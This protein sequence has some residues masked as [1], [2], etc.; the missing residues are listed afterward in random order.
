MER[1]D[2]L[3]PAV[4]L[5]GGL[6]TRL[7]GLFPELPKPMVPIAGR[8]FLEYVLRYVASSGIQRA[9]LCVG[10]R[11]EMVQAHF[12]TALRGGPQIVY[13]VEEELAGTG[14][15]IRLGAAVAPGPR[16]FAMN[17]DTFVQLDYRAMLQFHRERRSCLT[18]ALTE[19]PDTG[20]YG[21]VALDETGAVR[22]FGEKS[23]HGRGSI[24]AGVYLVEREVLDQIPAGVSSFERDVLT[25][26]V[27][28]GAFGFQTR[29]LFVDIGVPE[30]YQAL[31]TDSVAFVAATA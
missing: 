28:R 16:V 23:R 10:H 14:G 19:V 17:G 27:G 8:P 7:Q 22:A 1:A 24:N 3:P 13:S 11:R 31:A 2:Q 9:V 5:V 20:R 18:I 25:R 29:G 4:V 30:D 6:G 21:T 26:W 12:G 15:A